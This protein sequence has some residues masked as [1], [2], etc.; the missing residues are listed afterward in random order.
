[1]IE[2]I[3]SDNII[4]ARMNDILYRDTRLNYNIKIIIANHIKDSIWNIYMIALY[5]PC[6]K[7][8]DRKN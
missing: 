2:H 5:I 8:N 1:M 6:V 7:Y 3:E 4:F